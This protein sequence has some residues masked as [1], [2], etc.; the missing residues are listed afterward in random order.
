MT[1]PIITVIVPENHTNNMV[2]NWIYS[3][4]MNT[5]ARKLTPRPFLEYQFRKIHCLNSSYR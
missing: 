3:S 5:S 1:S 2:S 4:T